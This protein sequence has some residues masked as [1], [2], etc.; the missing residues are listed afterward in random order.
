MKLIIATGI[1]PP[2]I[3]GPAT[4]SKLLHDELPSRGIDVSILSFGEVRSYPKIVR[5]ALFFAKAL[6][7]AWSADVIF[8]QDTVSVG[9]PA[10]VAA[11]ILRKRFFVRVPGDYAW[12]QA[13]QRFG[14]TDSIDDFQTKKHNAQTEFLKS[15][16][17]FVVNGADV[18]ITPSLY[19]KKLVSGWCK[20]PDKVNAIYNGIELFKSTPSREEARNKLGIRSDE[21]VLV[22]AGRLVPWKGFELLIKLIAEFKREGKLFRLFIVGGG[23]DQKKLETLIAERDVI[24]QVKL[25]GSI[26]R[27][28]LRDYLCA[29]TA[30]VLNTGFESFSFQIVEAM[31]CGAPVVSTAIGN[32]PEIVES[33]KEGILVPYNDKEKLKGA[34]NRVVTDAAL[35]DR[36]IKN[37]RVKSEQ[38]SIDATIANLI[39]LL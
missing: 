19:F 10:L 5:H 35:R 7:R 36:F 11:R 12:E 17:R 1:Y 23:P 4:Y 6:K 28:T 30:F 15:V 16:Q 3:G 39:K 14:V 25:L 31:R 22:S 9:F 33:E 32:L 8:A 38:F 24:D 34:I 37:A 29:S 13:T 26:P 18:V 20:N 27:E 2:D 21:L